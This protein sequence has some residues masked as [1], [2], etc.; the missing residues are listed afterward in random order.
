MNPETRLR[1]DV[2]C[3]GIFLFCLSILFAILPATVVRAEG[4]AVSLSATTL[5]FEAQPPIYYTSPP[6]SVTLTNSGTAPLSISG[7]TL[8]GPNP[9]DFAITAGGDVCGEPVRFEITEQFHHGLVPA[10]PIRPFQRRVLGGLEEVAYLPVVLLDAEVGD[11][12]GN[13]SHQQPQI[14]VVAVVV[15][16]HGIAQPFH[17]VLE[18]GLP[19]LLLL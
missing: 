18:G 8:T 12:P 14:A 7:V 10:L 1:A 6:L 16:D 19:R 2:K 17:I 5:T 3:V 9:G 13:R 4:P 11:G 15:L